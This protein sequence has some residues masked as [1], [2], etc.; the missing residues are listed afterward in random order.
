MTCGSLRCRGRNFGEKA[1]TGTVLKWKPLSGWNTVVRVSRRRTALV[2]NV[3]AA[4]MDSTV[5]QRTV[6]NFLLYVIFLFALGKG[7]VSK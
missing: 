7:V 4:L 5:A 6:G 2:L 1:A 3:G